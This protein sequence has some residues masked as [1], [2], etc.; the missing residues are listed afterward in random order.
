MTSSNV[1]NITSD[2]SIEVSATIEPK[3]TRKPRTPK[4]ASTKINQKEVNTVPE[5][6]VTVSTTTSKRPRKTTVRPSST[7]P[8]MLDGVVLSNLYVPLNNTVDIAVTPFEQPIVVNP[9]L[10]G[11][12]DESVVLSTM[13]D[14]HTPLVSMHR[15][16]FDPLSMPK[17]QKVLADAGVGSR[18][19]MDDL[20]NAGS[21]KVNG[22]LAHTGQ[23][24]LITDVI[25]INGKIVQR[26]HT[27]K[28][29]RVILYHK[30]AGEIVSHSDPDGR[31]SVFEKMPRLRNGKWLSVGR[32]D[33]NTE[34]LLIVCNSGD[35]TN[36]MM[37]PRFGLEREYAVRVLGDLS[38][39]L[40]TKLR[41]GI[42]LEDGVAK[43]LE[44]SD[45]G[46]EGANKWYKVVLTEGKN[47]EVRRLF[48]AVGVVV[49]RLIRTRFG[50]VYLPS[51]LKRGQLQELDDAT[52]AQLMV[53]LGVWKD[54]SNDSMQ[55]NV[56]RDKINQPQGRRN[57][58]I[59]AQRLQAGQPG[60]ARGA[61]RRNRG[62]KNPRTRLQ[63]SY[64][65]QNSVYD[66]NSN[67]SNYQT[68]LLDDDYQPASY[69]GSLYTPESGAAG[70]VDLLAHTWKS[71]KPST[72]NNSRR[73]N[74]V[75][76]QE[77][78]NH[79]RRKP[80]ARNS[81]P[82]PMQ[83]SVGVTFNNSSARV[84]RTTVRKP[85]GL[86]KTNQRLS[87]NKK[88]AP[89]NSDSILGGMADNRSIRKPRTAKFDRMTG[90][91]S[92]RVDRLMGQSSTKRL[93]APAPVVTVLKKRKL[94]S[95]D[96]P[97]G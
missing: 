50:P 17:L 27:N 47:R 53:T 59:E 69:G 83:T 80:I 45:L 87:R 42:E 60:V 77:H 67:V 91:G 78:A 9:V 96:I 63:P 19:D 92:N 82:D 90:E 28:P 88:N 81:R 55:E 10:S 73:T 62:A 20:I 85:A 26:K 44:L 5:A 2:T 95:E 66:D 12:E 56:R 14:V 86:A 25:E 94:L 48:E 79:T 89:L 97:K 76:E 46:G 21:V 36:R 35:L 8:A 57:Q 58:R 29:P 22:E 72:N 18:R 1:L 37:H 40:Q 64:P 24:V 15:L 75:A 11:D 41:T 51:R 4:A 54:P 38:D 6:T 34:G 39:E 49:S 23:R 68:R 16:P 52:S 84:D 61:D 93:N 31:T 71:A 32:L 13:T 74:N 33:Y 30:P 43:F 3:K 65:S 7:L 70:H